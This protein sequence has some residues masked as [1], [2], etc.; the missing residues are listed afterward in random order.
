MGVKR[1][2]RYVKG[3][4]DYRLLYKKGESNE[5]LIGCSDSNFAGDCSDWKSTSRHIFFFGGMAVSWLTGR[6]RASLNTK[7]MV[8]QNL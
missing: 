8:K 7:T 6:F 2:L 1:V 4:E 5:E 3:I